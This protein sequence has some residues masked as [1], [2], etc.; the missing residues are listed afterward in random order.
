MEVSAGYKAN[1]KVLPDGDALARASVENF[2]VDA[3]K[4]ISSKGVFYVAISGGHTPGPFYQLLGESPQAKALPWDKIHLFWVD[5]R[6]V[7]QDSDR[8]NYKLA[9][10]TFLNKIDIPKSNIHPIPTH[11]TDYRD[12][13]HSYEQ[14]LREVFGLDN[15]GV[16]QFDLIVL[17]MGA[18]GHTGSLF[19][20]NYSSFDTEDLA[21]VVYVFDEKCNRI[22]LTRSVLCAA[23]NL[24]VIIAG[25][26]KA[27][28]LKDVLTGEP[29]EI[30]YPIHVLWPVLDRVKW[31]VEKNAAKYL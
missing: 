6:Y 22:T 10:D 31:F 11:C 18:D 27:Q 21:C 28:I 13:A 24:L 20:D 29:D 8:N 7:P 17:G 25:E 12:A 30:R 1:V 5:E 15:K 4:A 2:V 19:S 23:E 3:E 26:R 14:T 9:N 16:P